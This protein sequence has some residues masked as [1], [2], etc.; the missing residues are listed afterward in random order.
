MKTSAK[1]IQAIEGNKELMKAINNCKYY[2]VEQ[3]IGDA[4]RYIKAI[5]EGRM[6]CKIASVS[7]SGMSRQMRF[8]S[9][10]KNKYN[11]GN[12]NLTNYLCLFLALGFTKAGDNFRIGGCGM[13]MVF[14]TNYTIIHRLE[15]LGFIA[16]EAC[17]KLAQQTPVVI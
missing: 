5:Q 7:A 9:M 8:C 12:F 4:N 14:H 15:R 11:K 3:F 10:E 17:E 13:D 2:S 16:K 1:L 6:I